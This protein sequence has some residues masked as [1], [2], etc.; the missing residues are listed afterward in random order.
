MFLQ[1]SP[2]GILAGI[3]FP[4]NTTRSYLASY[5]TT[6]DTVIPGEALNNT[7]AGPDEE[8]WSL[9]RKSKEAGECNTQLQRPRTQLFHCSQRWKWNWKVIFMAKTV[10]LLTHLQ[11]GTFG[12]KLHVNFLIRL[13][14]NAHK[15]NKFGEKSMMRLCAQ[16]LH[17]A[18]FYLSN[19]ILVKF[20]PIYSRKPSMLSFGMQPNH[21]LTR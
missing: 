13:K 5:D 3:V 6:L 9:K 20:Y 2:R 18:P 1:L 10:P 7:N 15:F 16:S 21:N 12:I 17:F 8:E 14:Y 19:G 4:V 11:S